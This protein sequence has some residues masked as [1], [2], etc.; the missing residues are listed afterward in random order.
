MAI[1]PPTLRT[2]GIAAAVAG[3]VALAAPFAWTS[4]WPKPYATIQIPDT[5]ASANDCFIARGD[6]AP[7]TIW[8]PLWLIEAW[9]GSG[10]RP[11]EKID[12]SP[13]SWQRKVCVWGR[14][15]GKFQLALVL[16]DRDLDDDF[17]RP[18][19]DREDEIPE[20][21]KA[22]KDMQQGCSRRRRGF[23]PL[24]GG[25]TLI[26]SVALT[27]VEGEHEYCSMGFM[28]ESAVERLRNLQAA[29]RERDAK[30]DA[31]R[32]LRSHGLGDVVSHANR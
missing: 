14:T 1:R 27:V 15:G 8:R 32:V 11:L 31:R 5:Y 6:V 26:T 21:L 23:D 30:H 16:A 17:T 22:K 29:E 9:D 25:A 13:G 2:A 19:V 4:F 20:W 18:P 28:Y 7:S 12:P 24:P 10:W 3:A